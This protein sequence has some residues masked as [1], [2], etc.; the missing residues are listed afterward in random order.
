[1]IKYTQ[2][3]IELQIKLSE[4]IATLAHALAQVTGNQAA[5]KILLDEMVRLA[6]SPIVVCDKSDRLGGFNSKDWRDIGI[7]CPHQVSGDTQ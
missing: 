4:T 1:M 2:I 6:H 5:E 3:E 7:P